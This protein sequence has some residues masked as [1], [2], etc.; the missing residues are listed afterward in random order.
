[1]DEALRDLERG[2]AGLFG[3]GSVTWKVARESLAFLGGG[4]AALL[5]AAHPY[6]AHAIA[7]HSQTEHDLAGRFQRTFLNVFAM[8]FGTREEAVGSAERVFQIHQRIHGT[9]PEAVGG[10]PAGHRYHATDVDALY[11]VFATLLHT[12]IQ[13]RELVLGP[14][15]LRIKDAFIR[16]GVRFGALFGI[17]PE[18]MPENWTAFEARFDAMVDS[19]TIAV[20]SA[21]AQICHFL[22]KPPRRSV[23]P[24]WAWYR[25][26][27]A[28]LLPAKLRD[29][30]GMRWRRRDAALFRASIATL[31]RSY[32]RVPGRMR[33]LP[34]YTDAMRRLTGEDRPDPFGRVVKAV[35]LR[36]LAAK[37]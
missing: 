36:G 34:A 20:G 28:G 32:P 30:Y 4:R 9:F 11:W 31:R 1:M 21:G 12:S 24:V 2:D 18:V 26:M 22:L 5:Q 23:A 25:R 10:Y 13:V 8:V 6:V 14:V 37:T 17:P 19:H 3:P 29:A 33:Y 16:E 35:V 15:A 27:T 7:D